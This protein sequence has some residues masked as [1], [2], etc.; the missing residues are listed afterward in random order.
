MADPRKLEAEVE[1]LKVLLASLER[2]WRRIPWLLST[3]LLTIPALI[4]WGLGGGVLVLLGALLFAATA[5]Y[6]VSVRRREYNGE[7]R[8]VRRT[9]DRLTSSKR[10]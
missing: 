2:D 5:A 7:L 6:I 9:L 8:D 3:T 4:L 1:R 10:T